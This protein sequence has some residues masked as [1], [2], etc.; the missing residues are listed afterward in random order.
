MT[1]GAILSWRHLGLRILPVCVRSLGVA[2][3]A[4]LAFG[5]YMALADSFVFPGIVPTVLVAVTAST[6]ALDRVAYFAPLA[7]N[8]EL[9]FRLVVM[10]ALVW[11]LVAVAGKRDWCYWAAI[12]ITALVVYPALHPAYLSVLTPSMPTFTRE[13]TLHGAAGILWG[14]IYWRYGLVASIVGHVSAHLSLQP[15]LSAFA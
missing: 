13:I 9:M 11:V 15:L 2:L 7:M 3:V 1:A 14:Y 6:S 5:V 8:D 12:L 10:S 4:G